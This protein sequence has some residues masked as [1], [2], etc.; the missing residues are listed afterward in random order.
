MGKGKWFYQ[1]SRTCKWVEFDPAVNEQVEAGFQAQV[2]WLEVVVGGARYEVQFSKKRMNNTVTH[3]SRAIKREEVASGNP[4]E[5]NEYANPRLNM[6]EMEAFFEK[7]RKQSDS[8]DPCIQ[9]QG[10]IS[11]LDDLEVSIDDDSLLLLACNIQAAEPFKL[12]HTEF[13]KGLQSLEVDSISALKKAIVKWR[14]ALA[15]DRRC[16][17]Y[18]Y[19]FVFDWTREENSRVLQNDAAI[20]SWTVLLKGKAQELN[21]PLDKWCEF[22]ATRH[23]KAISKDAWKSLLDFMLSTK[24]DMSNY[25]EDEGWPVLMDE[26]VEWVKPQ[27]A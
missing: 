19:W 24:P 22:V 11:L 25:D 16:F 18:F 23:K 4:Y 10:L 20:E 27:L 8:D 9:G 1:D 14:R 2:G 7:H 17:K 6:R 12:G 3:G 21:F 13:I 5:I 26:F 15:T